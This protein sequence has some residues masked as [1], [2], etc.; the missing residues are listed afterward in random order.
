MP[1]LPIL[2][3]VDLTCSGTPFE[4]G[5]AQGTALREKIRESLDTIAGLEAVRLMKPPGMPF[6]V[7]RFLAEL[8]S[9][10]FLK[11]AFAAAPLAAEQRL[12]GIAQ[13]AGVAYRRLAFCN[14]VEAVLSDLE[15]ITFVPTEAGCTAIA[16]TQSAT[17]SGA[18]IVAHN[19]DYLPAIQP[20]YFIRRSEPDGLL[21]SVELGVTVAPGAVT[22]I[23]E[24]GLAIACNYA[25]ATDKN[26]PAPTITMAIAEAL[27]RCKSVDETVEFFSQTP[28]VGG[29]LLM[30]GDADGTIA[31]L[32]VS[33]RR[34][35]RRDPEP[36]QDYLGHTNRYCSPFMCSIELHPHATHGDR[37]PEVLRG[38]RVHKSS[39]LRDADL[40]RL[41]G[42]SERLDSDG[43]QRIMSDHG[44]TGEASADTICM[45]GEYWHTT[46]SLQLFPAERRL[47]ASFSPTCV[48]EYVDYSAAETV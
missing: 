29:G 38:R 33:N 15:P 21:R 45:H 42:S 13:G 1:S 25:F 4:M 47:R 22:G 5:F 18:P 44:P 40:E 3:V 46:A 41:L 43:V 48:A 35:K 34:L 19:F 12:Q 37:A 8:K 16:V 27:S 9:A 23:N 28:R 10:R 31:S 7:F 20:Y 11:R 6:R 14:A 17:E 30:L 26:R 39:E 24:A 2:P 32:E 36:E